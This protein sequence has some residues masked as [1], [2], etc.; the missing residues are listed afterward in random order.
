MCC[1]ADAAR[2]SSFPID[3]AGNYSPERRF[4]RTNFLEPG[5]FDRLT[6][7]VVDR[8]TASSGS[9]ARISFVRVSR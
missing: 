3:R 2:L 4:S 5:A 8:Q 6:C 7:G 9:G 1:W